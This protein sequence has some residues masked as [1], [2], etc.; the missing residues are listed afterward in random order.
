MIKE[1]TEIQAV[2]IKGVKAQKAARFDEASAAYQLILDDFPDHAD[3]NHLLGLVAHQLGEH[4][5]A[6]QLIGKAIKKNYKVASFHNNMG[7]V[8]KALGELKLAEDSYSVSLTIN[9][10]NTEALSNLGLTLAELGRPE[11][12]INCYKSALKINPDIL[13]TIMKLGILLDKQGSLDEAIEYF[14]LAATIN[15]KIVEI[16]KL[17][18][19]S[20]Y[21]LELF[22]EA[23]AS[24]ETAISLDPNVGENFTALSNIQMKL[25]HFEEASKSCRIALSINN[26]DLLAHNTLGAS[27]LKMNRLEEAE[28]SFRDALK[29]NSKHADTLSNLG[30][31]LQGKNYLKEA[32]ECYQKAILS[33]PN[34]A[35][36]HHRLGNVCDL[37]DFN[38]EAKKSY[39]RA[40]DL[41]S[42]NRQI[43]TNLALNLLRLGYL[44]EGW[45]YYESRQLPAQ[46]TDVNDNRTLT[47]DCFF[48]HPQWDGST[49]VG[50][51]IIL[52]GDQ[53][54]GDEVRFASIIS[55][56]QKTG[57]DITIDCDFRLTDVF[58]RSF[59]D[60]TIH[61]NWLGPDRTT[62]YDFDAKDTK[63]FDY[64]CTLAGLA[65]FFRNDYETFASNKPGYLRADPALIKFWKKRLK[66]ISA[67]PKVG[68]SWSN[69]DHGI[70]VPSREAFYASI[71]E[72]SPIL[73]MKGIDFVN[74]QSFESNEDIV[75]AKKWFDVEIHSWEDFDNRNDLNGV[76]ALTSCLDLVISFPTF[77]AE[78]A[79]ALGVPTIC[80]VNH[81]DGFDELGSKDNIWYQNTHHV[82][83]NR[84][85]SW[86]LVFEEIVEIVRLKF[87][88]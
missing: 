45:D 42:D 39:E 69:G 86:Q 10:N 9:P 29:I 8:R 84:N 21:K 87:K 4:N 50:K 56:L 35:E 74:L 88:L 31:I 24:L 40:L 1:S 68:L 66:D 19:I 23:E 63:Q 25:D 58:A 76:A 26:H 71:E 33:S 15:P 20:F 64:Q 11:E 85:E 28:A 32:K 73:H 67:K 81:K 65:R 7:N 60:A 75:R 2:L 38:N 57:A 62:P 3:A 82:C 14:K 79:G 52:W 18:S 61:G 17:I 46:Y 47:K 59:S 34:M 22:P 37:Q 77:S 49:L 54:I 72:L 55:D 83:K 27:L 12:A 16:H 30:L 80:F 78:F 5:R 48:P 70:N 36:Y 13:G 41:D 53:G 6:V 43:K 44:K 51:S